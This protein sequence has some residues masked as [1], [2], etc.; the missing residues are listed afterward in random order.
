MKFFFLKKSLEFDLHGLILNQLAEV[1]GSDNDATKEEMGRLI[2][3]C[4]EIST[5]DE[6]EKPIKIIV[7]CSYSLFICYSADEKIILT[8]CGFIKFIFFF[9][10]FRT[11]CVSR[12]YQH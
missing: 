1:L 11:K 5:K 3:R 8:R 10:T 6:K 7:S 2:S 9:S 12:T 4:P